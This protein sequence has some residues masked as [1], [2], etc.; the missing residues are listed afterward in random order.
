MY[1]EV[2]AKDTIL[3]TCEKRNDKVAN[4]VRC[5]IASAVSDIHAADARYHSD[6]MQGVMSLSGESSSA[7]FNV[8]TEV[9]G[10]KLYRRDG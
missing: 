10:C 7:S 2:N 5:L 9:G 6:C 3:E 4:D 8:Y 1:R